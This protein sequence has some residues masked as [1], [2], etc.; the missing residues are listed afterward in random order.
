MKKI[1]ELIPFVLL[2]I[3]T[4][5][6]LLNELVFEWGQAAT[7]SFAAANVMGLLALGYTHWMRKKA[8]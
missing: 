1:I 3:G 6:L 8:G 2:I 4:L 5:G 7:L